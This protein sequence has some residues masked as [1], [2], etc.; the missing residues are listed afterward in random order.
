MTSQKP[1]TG[2]GG[3]YVMRSHQED[4]LRF[5]GETLVPPRLTTSTD[6][7]I[8]PAVRRQILMDLYLD[9]PAKLDSQTWVELFLGDDWGPVEN[10]KYSADGMED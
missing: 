7:P 4:A 8:C 3:G 9:F 6:R 1:P 5:L 10:P 2:W